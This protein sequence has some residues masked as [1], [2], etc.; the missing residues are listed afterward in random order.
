L[1]TTVIVG[2][3]SLAVL[4]QCWIAVLWWQANDKNDYNSYSSLQRLTSLVEDVSF[5]VS[6]VTNEK[7]L[8]FS[9]QS[10]RAI[11]ELSDRKHICHKNMTNAWVIFYH[12]FIPRNPPSRTDKALQIVQEQLEQIGNS[13]YVARC[14]LFQKG[15]D[16]D[17]TIINSSSNHHA[18]SPLLL[19]TTIGQRILPEV[20]QDM[21]QPLGIRCVDVQSLSSGYEDKTLRQVHAYCSRQYAQSQNVVVTYIHNKGSHHDR[22]GTNDLWRRHMTMAVTSK[23][24]YDTV[25]DSE[26]QCHAC[27][28]LFQAIPSWHFPGNFW[29]ARC[30]YVQKLLHPAVFMTK[31]DTTLQHMDRLVANGILTRQLYGY[32]TEDWTTGHGRYGH[33]QWIASHPHFHPCDV[34]ASPDLRFWKVERRSSSDF[35]WHLFPRRTLLSKHWQLQPQPNA[36]VLKHLEQ[37]LTDYHLLPGMMVRWW[38]LYRTLPKPDAWV[39]E[40]MPDGSIWRDWMMIQMQQS[41]S[42]DKPFAPIA[43]H[44]PDFTKIQNVLPITS[45]KGSTAPLKNPRMNDSLPWTVFYH[46]YSPF[47]RN[48][49]HIID[50]QLRTVNESHAA[51]SRSQSLLKV[52]FSLVGDGSHL[53][54]S[55]VEDICQNYSNLQCE[56]VHR[57]QQGNENLTLNAMYQY[58]LDNPDQNQTVIYF[59]S[60]GS[61]HDTVENQYWRRHLL[62]AITSADCLENMRGSGSRCN[63]CGLQFFPVWA[64]FFPGNFF[65]SRCSYISK[66]LAP[67]T[68]AE[69]MQNVSKEMLQLK[70]E[71]F[72]ETNLFNPHK[73]GTLGLDRYAWEHWVGSHPSI[74]PCDLSPTA[75]FRA[76]VKPFHLSNISATQHRNFKWSL[77]P[78]V[79]IWAP[80]YRI[81]TGK[82]TAVMADQD[83]R[84]REYFLLGGLL[85]KWNRLYPSSPVE[86]ENWVYDWFPDGRQ[87]WKK[88]VSRHGISILDLLINR[89]NRQHTG[90]S[91][92]DTLSM[93]VNATN[94]N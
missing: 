19:Y 90:L 15:N 84:L 59:H 88:A 28:L 12:I 33:E 10:T 76:W 55:V 30:D 3:V 21:C 94:F 22:A 75:N 50:E 31:L 56:L 46:V 27:G 42:N 74:R 85:F 52:Y 57:A 61:Y 51:T 4:F 79:D 71:G 20:M 7:F 47:G 86:E 53:P 70:K 40:H 48:V 17:T 83:L 32:H 80:W 39:F 58:C 72:F 65:V 92:A 38:D 77:A 69:G 34:S 73:E 1:W 78:R 8:S 63:V 29:T 60:K 9:S 93:L 54:K 91:V 87:L 82:R 16:S 64:F 5:G 41:S 45:T 67:N 37:R 49:T 11:V 25:A 26:S 18:Q 23:E 62:S 6:N 35:E 44:A 66:L 24:C 81:Q 2:N 68:F 89:I 43:S 14:P 36:T 13:Y